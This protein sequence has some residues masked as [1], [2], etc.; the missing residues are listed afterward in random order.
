MKSRKGANEIAWIFLFSLII[1]VSIIHFVLMISMGNTFDTRVDRAIN[2]EIAEVK[3]RSVVTVTMNDYVWR[4]GRRYEI[5]PKKYGQ[6]TAL[7]VASM[8]FVEGNTVYIG[9]NSYSDEDVKED[10]E[11][12]FKYKMDKYWQRGGLDVKYRMTLVHD[13]QRIEVASDSYNI[14]E[15]E[16]VVTYPVALTDGDTAYVILRTKTSGSVYGVTNTPDVG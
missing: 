12:Y 3:K 8:Y 13:G 14:N 10:L 7:E 2:Y 11:Q 4:M 6:L 15:V 5:D 1:L 16:A 9:E